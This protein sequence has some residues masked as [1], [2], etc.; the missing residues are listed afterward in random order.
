MP[1]RW[2]DQPYS[3][4]ATEAFSKDVHTAPD[5]TAK[6]MHADEKFQTSHGAYY[7]ATQMALAHNGIIRGLN[8]IYLQAAALPSDDTTAVRDFLTY[9]QCWCE[10]M[11]HHHDVEEETFFPAIE[12]V[13][14]QPGLMQQ[15][16]DQHAAFTP[17]FVAFN[18][19]VESCAPQDYDGQEIKRLIEAFA[20]PLRQHLGDEINSLRALDKYDSV[21]V[22]KAYDQMDR[23]MRVTD[24]VSLISAEAAGVQM[25]I[26]SHSSA[27]LRWSSERRTRRSK[28][29]GMIFQLCL[30]SCR[31]LSTTCSSVGIVGRGA[32]I[33]LRAGG[34]LESWRSSL[35]MRL[36]EPQ[37]EKAKGVIRTTDVL[38]AWR[39]KEGSWKIERRSKIDTQYA[40]TPDPLPAR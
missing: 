29:A 16:V 40:V 11:H 30:S 17:G 2:A 10:S 13:S 4:I 32:S 7:A 9:C 25:L 26:A 21:E 36:G 34:N 23:L 35:R 1:S 8:S 6:A 37:R 38:H 24:N 27:S 20:E 28:V 18:D 19:Y 15:N 5:T 33:R 39:C 3:L 31:I 22:R 14:D 12:R